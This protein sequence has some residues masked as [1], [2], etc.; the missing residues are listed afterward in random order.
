MQRALLTGIILGAVIPLVGVIVVV[1]R[2]SMIGDALSHAS[3]AGVAAGLIGGINPVLGATLA[4]VVAAGFVEVIRRRF[5]ERAELAIALV[6][7]TGVGL[8]G[9]LS[10][11]VPNA[12]SFSSFLFGSIVTVSDEEVAWVVGIGVMVG[13]GC[14]ALRRQLFLMAADERAARL[15]GVRTGLVSAGFTLACALVVSIASRTVGALIVSA[16]MVVPVACGLQVARSWRSLVTVSCAVGVGSSVAGLVV[17]YCLGTKPGGSIVLVGIAVLLACFALRAVRAHLGRR[18]A[19]GDPDASG[20]SSPAPTG[21]AGSGA[22][23]L[24]AGDSCPADGPLPTD[25]RAVLPTCGRTPGPSR[26]D[27][28]AHQWSRPH[29]RWAGPSRPRRCPARRHVAP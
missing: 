26:P 20:H 29:S 11:F 4:A 24:C 3:L 14:V 25:G 1:R 12:S 5:A 10:G 2:L 23:A 16:M 19:S 21:P 18:R 17:S 13:A 15:A 27:P 6:M 28:R 9:V 8:A 22:S 7:A